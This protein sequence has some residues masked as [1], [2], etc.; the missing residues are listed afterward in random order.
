MEVDEAT[1]IATS[2]DFHLR[3]RVSQL[4]AAATR[5]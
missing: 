1:S 3:P 2:I 4:P 5:P